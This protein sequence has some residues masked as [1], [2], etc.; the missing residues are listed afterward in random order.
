MEDYSIV[1]MEK[2][3]ETGF[4][5]KELGSYSVSVDIGF[6]DR[7]YVLK[8]GDSKV[9]YLY[10]TI[11]GDFK[12]WEFNAILDNY[13]IVQYNGKVISIEEDEDCYNPTWLIKFNYT[14]NDTE[15]EKKLNEILEMHHIEAEKILNDIK[16]MEEDY[17]E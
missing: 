7:V 12:D 5:N 1:L 10:I 11:P 2:D 16:S 9:T 3:I 17:K 13:N 14:Q 4:L 8:E 15:M 6:F